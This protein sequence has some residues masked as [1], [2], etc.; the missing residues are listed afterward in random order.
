MGT[1]VNL[2]VE[3]TQ[4]NEEKVECIGLP[5]QRNLMNMMHKD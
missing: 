2:G 4:V 5:T 3:S 1:P